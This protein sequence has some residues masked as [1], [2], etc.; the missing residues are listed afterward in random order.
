MGIVVFEETAFI[1]ILTLLSRSAF[2]HMIFIK[3]NTPLIQMMIW[4][5]TGLKNVP[6][7]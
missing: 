2:L 3:V 6:D 4:L 1:T 5:S 7:G